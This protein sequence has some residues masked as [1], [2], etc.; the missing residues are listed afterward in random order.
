MGSHECMSDEDHVAWL[1]ADGR[2][3]VRLLDLRIHDM[4]RYPSSERVQS[5][6][7][8]HS[9]AEQLEGPF[10]RGTTDAADC[11]ADRSGVNKW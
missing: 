5:H 2:G 3:D 7:A 4:Q 6:T 1:S 11:A 8:D 10:N 9:A